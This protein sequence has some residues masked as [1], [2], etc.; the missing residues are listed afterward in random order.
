[1]TLK[2]LHLALLLSWS[3]CSILLV[4]HCRC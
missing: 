3:L 4:P 2:P 1:M